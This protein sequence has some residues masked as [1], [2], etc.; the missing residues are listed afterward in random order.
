VL[1]KLGDLRRSDDE[2][3]A[4][5][6]ILEGGSQYWKRMPADIQRDIENALQRYTEGQFQ[7]K[8]SG[9]SSQHNINHSS[10]KLLDKDAMKVVAESNVSASNAIS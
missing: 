9:E 2:E 8:Y 1:Q 7:T 4:K 6:D 3:Y 5:N 10:S